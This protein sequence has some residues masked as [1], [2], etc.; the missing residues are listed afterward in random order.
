MIYD[1]LGLCLFA[2]VAIRG[3]HGILA[4]LVNGRWGTNLTSQD[5]RTM[6]IQ[7]LEAERAFNRK[8]GLGPSSDR[9]PEIF[10]EEVNPSSGTVFDISPSE[11]D[12]IKYT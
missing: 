6:A 4:D 11:L 3:H 8:A 2:H 1:S 7:A 10:C 5:L 9:I 12:E